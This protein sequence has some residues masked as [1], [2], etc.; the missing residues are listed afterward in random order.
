MPAK[1]MS[2]A[3]AK[4]AVVDPATGR[5]RIVGI[6]SS[7]SYAYALDTQEVYILGRYSPAEI[8]YTAQEAVRGSCT[9]WRSVKHGPHRE[10]LV[11]KLQDLLNHEYIEMAVIDRQTEQTDPNA[12][13]MAKINFVRP[14]GFSTTVNARQLQEVTMTF[15]GLLVS[16]EEGDHGESPGAVSLP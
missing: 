5:I 15:V 6:T 13:R 1:T 11:P 9:G 3:R 2:G 16:D 12:A 4:V 7:I 10:F 8:E 14:T